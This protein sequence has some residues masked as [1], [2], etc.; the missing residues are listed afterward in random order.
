ML[1]WKHLK[2][3]GI[4]GKEA[5]QNCYKESIVVR[6]LKTLLCSCFLF[7]S[8]YHKEKVYYLYDVQVSSL[9]DFSVLHHLLF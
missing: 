3:L 1:E 9:V 2:N 7:S 8:A 5:N 6:L 4:S